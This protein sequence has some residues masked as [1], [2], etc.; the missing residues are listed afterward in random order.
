MAR[1]VFFSF[2]YADVWRVNQV[3]NSNVVY[4]AQEAGF[5]DHSEYLERGGATPEYI[6]RVIKEKLSDTTVTIVLVGQQ[7]ATR[8]WVQEEIRLSVE[9]GNGLLGVFVHHLRTPQD[10]ENHELLFKL[11][12]TMKPA[13]PT[14]PGGVA[15]PIYEWD[16]D[17]L[18]FAAALE[19]AGQRGEQR[20]QMMSAMLALLRGSKT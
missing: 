16:R 5:Y 12:P 17:P 9:R 6:R 13:L 11:Y 15:F 19:A 14:I 1:R 8:P 3:R 4:G 10:P 18:R 2:H 20:A 7:T